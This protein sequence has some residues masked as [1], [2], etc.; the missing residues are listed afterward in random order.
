MFQLPLNTTT[1]CANDDK[2]FTSNLGF[3]KIL[4]ISIKGFGNVKVT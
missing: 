1:T 4:G 2:N 3:L